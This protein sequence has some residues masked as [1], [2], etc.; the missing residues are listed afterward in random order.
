MRKLIC[1]L[2]CLLMSLS[3]V[4]RDVPGR[5][6]VGLMG[7]YGW[8]ETWKGYGGADV[9]GFMPFHRF[10]EATAVAELH[11]PGISAFTATARP[12][13][14]LPVGELFADGSF[15]FRHL[16]PYG[17]SDLN[18]AVSAG[19]RMDYVSVQFGV[20]SHLMIDN[21]RV[22]NLSPGRVKEPANFLYRVAFNVRPSSCRWN[23]GAGVADYTD[24]EY[25]HSCAPIYFI[26]GH[27]DLDDNFSVLLRGDL[28]PSGVI[29]MNAQFWGISFRAGVEYKF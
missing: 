23:A 12:K 13:Y 28:K 6:S 1:A 27:Y 2:I 14:Q 10:F 8:N 17:V 3:A 7:M 26:H 9:V 22:E 29:H 15:H 16:A 19:Y 5:Y 21:E 25:E 24:F 20:V 18:L 4:A 11:S